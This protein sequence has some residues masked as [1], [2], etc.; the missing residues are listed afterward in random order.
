MIHDISLPYFI[1]KPDALTSDAE[2]SSCFLIFTVV[3]TEVTSVGFCGV[4]VSKSPPVR[5]HGSVQSLLFSL[6]ES[7]SGLS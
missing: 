3:G 6:E 5:G 1:D 4:A 2:F 7:E